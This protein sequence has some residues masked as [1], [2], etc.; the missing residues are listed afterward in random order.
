VQPSERVSV[1]DIAKTIER[2]PPSPYFFGFF[3]SQFPN[4]FNNN[5]IGLGVWTD[6]YCAFR[7]GRGGGKNRLTWEIVEHYL[8]SALYHRAVQFS[9]IC[10]SQTKLWERVPGRFWIE[11][12]SPSRQELIVRWWEGENIWP[13]CRDDSI[14]LQ[15]SCCGGIFRVSDAS[16]HIKQLPDEQRSLD[17]SDTEQKHSEQNKPIRI[18]RDP[19]RFESKFF[20]DFGFVLSLTF[21]F[22][23]VGLG[24]GVGSI[25]TV[26]GT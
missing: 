19:L 1:F 25:F 26:I 17:N 4:S 6:N 18:I 10:E 15:Q 23:G 5:R 20:I 8:S 14:S 11:S 24:F 13:L 2:L 16:P 12:S 21:L 22:I 7:S 3:G 9:D